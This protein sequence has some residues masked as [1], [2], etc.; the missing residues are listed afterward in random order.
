MKIGE[1]DGIK[2]IQLFE[3]L[4]LHFCQNKSVEL[5]WSC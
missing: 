3:N 2:T 5:D 1:S 4:D